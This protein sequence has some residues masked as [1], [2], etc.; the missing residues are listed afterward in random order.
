M[1]K[2][3]EIQGY[4]VP[5]EVLDILNTLQTANF[6][7]YLVGGCVR[8][9][10]LGQDPKDWDITTNAKPEEIQGLF[11]HT[12]YENTYG[13]VKIINDKT[14]NKALKTIEVTTHRVESEY[15]DGRHPD[16]V[17]FSDKIEEDLSRRDF[18][19]NAMAIELQGGIKD[20]SK[21]HL[22]DPYK[23]HQD[24]QNK[25]VRTVLEPKKKFSEDA[26]RI[27]RAVRL[28]TILGFSIEKETRESMKTLAKNLKDI[29]RERIRDEFIK[30]IMSKKP[31][32]GLTELK[33][34]NLIEYT[35]PEFKESVGVEQGGI[36]AYDVWEHSLKTLQA[37]ANKDF[38]L[39]VRLA[40][41]FH[42]I[43]KP[44]TRRK[45]EKKEWT[46][47]GHDA[48]GARVTHET[49]ESL[50]FP[51]E[52]IEKVSNL[53]RNH[54]FFSDTEQI[55]HSAVR[56]IIRNVGK[57]NI[58]DLINLRITDRVGTGRPKEEPYRLRKY[59]SM[60]EEVMRDPIS[61]GMLEIDGTR[62]M[63]VTHETPGP[64]I[65]L[66]LHA[67]LEEVLDDPKLNT[68]EYLEKRTGELVKLDDFKLIKLGE[69][70]KEKGAEREEEELKKIRDK[71]W[72][73]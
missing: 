57:E 60:I 9:I 64:K 21:G 5:N 47:Y 54:M 42:D 26:L 20:I 45:G 38:P 40:S 4:I 19:M 68:K 44:R 1:S 43:A 18:T 28:S 67:L 24:I 48:V 51:K 71:N 36:H 29:S 53:V 6:K 69:K 63:E 15:S 46:F 70:G 49:L 14:E 41:L 11:P 10:L 31:E 65:G 13:T 35:I 34:L 27:M 3:I 25:V 8:D 16:E 72:V 55:T 22:I 73:K 39:E 37:A 2:N 23:G 61:V 66:I 52:T 32:Y 12:Y 62:I 7:A 33:K 50:K 58:W 17:I 56:R 59:K 30:I